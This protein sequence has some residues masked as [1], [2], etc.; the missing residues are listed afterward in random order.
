MSV[1]T[2]ANTKGGA[3][4]TTAALLLATEY[5]RQGYRVAVLDADPQKWITAWSEA[6]GGAANLEIISQVTATSLPSLIREMRNRIDFFIVDLAGARNALLGTALGISDH[7]LIPVQGCAMDARGAAQVLELLEQLKM[8]CGLDIAH[9]VVLTRVSS[10][11]TTRALAAVKAMLN[12][13]GV[14][15][16]ETPLNERSAY[17]DVFEYGATLYNADPIAISNLDKAR[18]NARTFAAEVKALLPR[19]VGRSIPGYSL[20]TWRRI[21]AA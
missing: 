3:G 16:L 2:L 19:K 9:S 4:K 11:V 8:Q 7:V 21:R 15:V 6:S 13:R 18:D 20:P 5:A 12:A 10:L 14:N 1:I 17:R